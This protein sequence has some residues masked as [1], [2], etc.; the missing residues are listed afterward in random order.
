M[1]PVEKTRALFDIISIQ[2]LATLRLCPS[3]LYEHFEQVMMEKYGIR[4][5]S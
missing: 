4:E 5:E 1:T 3:C 2:D